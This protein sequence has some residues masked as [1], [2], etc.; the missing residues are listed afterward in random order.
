MANEE[1]NQRG[2]L[3]SGSLKG[4]AFGTFEEL[5]IGGTTVKELVANGV[6]ALVPADMASRSSSSSRPKSPSPR[7]RTAFCSGV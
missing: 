7:S 5:D 1:L 4:K 2:Y 3:T 6:Q